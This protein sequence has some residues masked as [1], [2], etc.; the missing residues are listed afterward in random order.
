M[1]KKR[2][3]PGMPP[4]NEI[5]HLMRSGSPVAVSFAVG[6]RSDTGAAPLEI[7]KKTEG[8][9]ERSSRLRREKEKECTEKA[10][11][12]LD[13]TI[14]EIFSERNKLLKEIQS[15]EA[16]YKDYEATYGDLLLKLKQSTETQTKLSDEV[17]VKEIQ[18]IALKDRQFATH[19]ARRRLESEVRRIY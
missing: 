4:F 11:V 14:S 5:A 18:L 13:T 3:H 19:I 16:T 7:V 2:D 6:L 1:F 10:C 15:I 8:K 9:Q 17:H 12:A